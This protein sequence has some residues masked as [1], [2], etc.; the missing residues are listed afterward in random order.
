MKFL[1]AIGVAAAILSVAEAA[2]IGHDQVQ[3]FPQP[4]PVTDSEKAAIKFKPTLK[5]DT[6]C[7]PYPVVN[8]AG[9]VSAGLKGTG[10]IDGDCKGSSLGSQV[11]GRAAWYNDLWAIMY[12]WYFP[13][14][15]PKGWF[16]GDGRRHDWVNVVVWID[17]PALERP[18]VIGASPSTGGDS[19][20]RLK[21]PEKVYC[22]NGMTCEFTYGRDPYN[23]YHT[24]GTNWLGGGLSQDLIMWEQLTDAARATLNVTDFGAPIVVPF[25]DA[26]FKANLEKAWPL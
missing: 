16:K 11:Y 22:V 1:T 13:K 3:P 10:K 2:A 19:Y 12:S 18:T 21:P 9:D 14:D 17:N 6:G 25:I 15:V 8:D 26:N 20:A 4:E 23:G 5:I 7:H 24:I